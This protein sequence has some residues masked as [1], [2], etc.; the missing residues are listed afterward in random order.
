MVGK[1]WGLAHVFNKHLYLT[2]NLI[3]GDFIPKKLSDDPITGEV[4]GASSSNAT[5]APTPKK[6]KVIYDKKKGFSTVAVE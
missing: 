4:D 5:P 6:L 3:D 1:I 2:R